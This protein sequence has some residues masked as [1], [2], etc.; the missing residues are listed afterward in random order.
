MKNS[1]QAFEVRL[2]KKMQPCL[3]PLRSLE[4]YYAWRLK[5]KDLKLIFK[6][7]EDRLCHVM[8]G[9]VHLINTLIL[10]FHMRLTLLFIPSYKHDIL[11]VS[12]DVSNK[13]HNESSATLNL[14]GKFIVSSHKVCAYWSSYFTVPFFFVSIL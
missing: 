2:T 10:C 5:V 8:E 9:F 13:C 1:L 14:Q 6:V 4:L 12:N 11:L 3:P 7:S